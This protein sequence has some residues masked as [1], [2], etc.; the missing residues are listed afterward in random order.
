MKRILFVCAVLSVLSACKQQKGDTVSPTG[1]II[2]AVTALSQNRSD[3]FNKL[4][5]G[6]AAQKYNS[7][8]IQKDLLKSLGD[9]RKI[10]LGAEKILSHDVTPNVT[11]TVSSVDVIKS[12]NAIYTVITRC[13]QVT[14]HSSHTVCPAPAV[15]YYP[16]SH[17]NGGGGFGGGHSSSGGG[18]SWG[19]SD[20]GYITPGVTHEVSPSSGSGDDG[21][22]PGNN[23]PDR[24]PRFGVTFDTS[25]DFSSSDC[26]EVPDSSV[27]VS[28]KIIDLQ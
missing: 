12:G 1:I 17:H 11:S 20:S 21:H 8:E 6:V 26:Y 19:G 9:V 4:L 25:V 7:P 18:G 24:P 15:P 2:E 5:S 22:K 14:T 27:T 16:P 10:T 28:C 23:D 3:D 13:D